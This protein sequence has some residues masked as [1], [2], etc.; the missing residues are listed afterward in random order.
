MEC[1]NCGK[2]FDKDEGNICGDCGDLFCPEC[3][4]EEVTELITKI[5][6]M[7]WIL[8]SRVWR[9]IIKLVIWRRKK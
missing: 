1:P 7:I 8:L 6:M 2:E 4:E 9:Q 5:L 3:V